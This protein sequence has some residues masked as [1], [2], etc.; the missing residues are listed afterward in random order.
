VCV[1]DIRPVEAVQEPGQHRVPNV[2]V[3]TWHR[4]ILDFARKPAP[5]DDVCVMV[6]DSNE[7]FWNGSEIVRGVSVADD[8]VFAANEF[9]GVPV[10][11]PVTRSVRF[12]DDSPVFPGYLGCLIGR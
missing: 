6:G 12:D 3:E 11:V 2:P 10:G 8:D 7:Q 9:E 4:P 5:D 1:A